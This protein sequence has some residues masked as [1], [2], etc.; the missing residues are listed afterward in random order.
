MKKFD[1]EQSIT[2]LKLINSSIDS[3]L[4]LFDNVSLELEPRIIELKPTLFCKKCAG[5]RGRYEL[6]LIRTKTF[7]DKILEN[8]E[9]PSCHILIVSERPI[10]K[11][12]EN[13][14][15]V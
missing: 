2:Q 9:C 5:N 12:D 13:K 8:Y 10:R 3:I 4:E 6:K 11:K 15:E 7:A 14:H 1:I